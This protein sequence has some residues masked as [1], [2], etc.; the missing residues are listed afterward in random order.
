MLH[1]K[2]HFDKYYNFIN[3]VCVI[4]WL[5]ILQNEIKQIKVEM[6]VTIKIYLKFKLRF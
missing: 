6:T 1:I 4:I 3:S 2:E 5:I